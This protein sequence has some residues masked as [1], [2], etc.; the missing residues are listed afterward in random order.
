MKIRDIMNESTK[1]NVKP[2]DVIEVFNFYNNKML[3]VKVTS[4]PYKDD[5]DI[6]I[7]YQYDVSGQLTKPKFQTT[8]DDHTTHWTAG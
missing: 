6:Y 8:N 5:G 7:D 3:K 4:K 1:L 2:G